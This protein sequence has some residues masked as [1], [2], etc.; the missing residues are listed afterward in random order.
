MPPSGEPKAGFIFA[1]FPVVGNEILVEDSLHYSK[2]M[3]TPGGLVAGCVRKGTGSL[4]GAV[5]KHCRGLPVPH[6]TVISGCQGGS[7]DPSLL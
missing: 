7:K 1:V 6:L 3:T 4:R 2:Q 5:S